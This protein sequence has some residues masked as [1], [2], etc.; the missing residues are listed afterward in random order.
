MMADIECP[1]FQ[2]SLDPFLNYQQVSCLKLLFLIKMKTKIQEVANVLQR[3][4]I[5]ANNFGL[6]LATDL[7][8]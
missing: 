6:E 7:G 2:K 1:S 4:N 3:Y 8:A 5:K